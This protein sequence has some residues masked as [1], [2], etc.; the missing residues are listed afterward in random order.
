MTSQLF[1]FFIAGFDTVSTA[2]IFIVYE[3]SINP[4]IMQRLSDEV[5]QVS[6]SLEGKLPKYEDLQKMEYLD[7]VV[8]EGLR[9]WPPVNFLDRLCSNKTTIEDYDGTKVEL[10]SGQ[11]ILIPVKSI[12][13]DHRYFPNPEKFDPERFS[14]ANRDNIDPYSYLV[15]GIGPRNCIG[16]R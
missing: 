15:F 4:E 10:E 3:L 16:N 8:S 6:E 13:M 5:D 11:G 1:L 2:M 14:S 12:H 7:M 9:K